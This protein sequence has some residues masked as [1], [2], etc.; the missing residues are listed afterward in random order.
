MITTRASNTTPRSACRVQ[1]SAARTA[2]GRR[3]R[4]TA[5]GTV[6]RRPS[7]PMSRQGPDT[8]AQPRDNRS[9]A[10]RVLGRV[11]PDRLRAAGETVADRSVRAVSAG[12]EV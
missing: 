6:G 1:R 12:T 10:G 11:D 2:P 7:A 5:H 3:A 8:G 9:S 4:R